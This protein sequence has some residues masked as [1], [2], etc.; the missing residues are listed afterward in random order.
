MV[1]PIRH[2]LRLILR[3]VLNLT[4]PLIFISLHPLLLYVV[5]WVDFIGHHVHL[6]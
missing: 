3:V 6:V 5:H 2:R 1:N 4:C